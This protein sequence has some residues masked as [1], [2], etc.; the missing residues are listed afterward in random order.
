MDLKNIFE[1][2]L[3]KI[4]IDTDKITINMNDSANG[5]INIKNIGGGKLSG[6]IVSNTECV[7]L[8]EEQFEGN[9]LSIEYQ[10]IPSIYNSG[11]FIK[12]EIIIISNGGEVIIPVFITVSNFDYLL[13]NT[14]KVYNIKQFYNYYL[15]NNKEAIRI[16][17]SFEFMIW[18][19]NIDFQHIEIT[20][21]FLKDT[22][23]HRGID[24]F[25]VI[26]KVKD[27]ATF[28]LE[29]ITYK[30]R[31]F[32]I[33]ED[34][35]IGNIP[36]NMIGKG[37]FETD[38]F[39]LNDCDWIVLDNNKVFSK[40]F[41]N[42][43]KLDF[44]FK[45]IKS[46]LKENFQTAK[47]K[48]NKIE[49]YVNVEV[50]KKQPLQIILER[51]YYEV[52]DIGKLKIINNLGKD[53]II[54]ILPKDTFIRFEGEKYLIGKYTE[55]VFEIK[56]SAFLKAQIDFTKKPYIET[57]ILIRSNLEDSIF[58]EKKTIFIGNSFI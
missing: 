21:S 31:Y 23:K 2:P 39:V 49:K 52:N 19:K 22:N 24:N 13:C 38:V 12:S 11:D 5:Y 16:F 41:N 50:V 4:E 42:D 1:Y 57:D 6:R 58:K 29:E 43:G 10:V 37:F 47:I 51:E 27:K 18:L 44:K 55:I 35:I 28:D 48:F 26:S 46:K 32:E 30:Y 56:L 8:L 36:L 3:P 14:E 20:E 33:N 34:D 45:I 9:N 53:I 54:E 15:K 40:D 7:V 17:N 25:F